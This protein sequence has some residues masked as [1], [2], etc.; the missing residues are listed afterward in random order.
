METANARHAPTG[1]AHGRLQG[2]Q[3]DERIRGQGCGRFVPTNETHGER[4]SGQTRRGRQKR[5][6]KEASKT[7]ACVS[8]SHRELGRIHASKQISRGK[9]EKGSWVEIM[10][11]KGQHLPRKLKRG[12]SKGTGS[13]TERMQQQHI[14]R[15]K[16]LDL[17]TAGASYQQI[18]DANIGY[19]D[20]GHVSHDMGKI[21]AEFQYE[22]PEDVLVLDLA[23]LDEMQRIVTFELRKG[24]M[25]CAN[26]LLRIMQF[27]RDTLGMTPQ[28]IEERRKTAQVGIHNN[29]IMV[30]QGTSQ[31]YIEAMM[32]AAGV[33][34]NERRKE[35]ERIASSNNAEN[36][37]EKDRESARF[38]IGSVSASPEKEAFGTKIESS[39]SPSGALGTKSQVNHVFGENGRHGEIIDAE[40]VEE[41]KSEESASTPLQAE[42]KLKTRRDQVLSKKLPPRKTSKKTY[43]NSS[44]NDDG[45]KPINHDDDII[46]RM[47][48]FDR[49][50]DR[51]DA[52]FERLRAVPLDSPVTVADIPAD[53]PVNAA[54]DVLSDSQA[55]SGNDVP[56]TGSRRLRRQLNNEYANEH[57]T[58]VSYR[59]PPR[60]PP[61]R[62]AEEYEEFDVQDPRIEKI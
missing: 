42:K 48:S 8:S 3:Q 47:R 37:M 17:R 14:R 46:A 29:G 13:I 41:E 57:R 35:I 49:K 15:R 6:R 28:V 33:P 60:K 51:R 53:V 22:T 1:T 4:D 19:R 44:Q 50:A 36:K 7:G 32:K 26:T 43:Q 31:D 10:P 5:G 24:D 25:S 55:S 52:E 2:T 9:V 12:R 11:S 58:A 18:V 16:A 45:G 62:L 40:I 56:K 23:R 39:D 59:Q 34:E 27:R 38:P 54:G 30:V 21:L 61:G 20:V